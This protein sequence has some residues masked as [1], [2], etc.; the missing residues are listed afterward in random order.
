MLNS[1]KIYSYSRFEQHKEKKN[2]HKSKTLES[3][4]KLSPV[5]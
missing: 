4:Y 3:I 1:L 2:T 5:V